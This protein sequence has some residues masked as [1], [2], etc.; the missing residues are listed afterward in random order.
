MNQL[1]KFLIPIW[2]WFKDWW[3]YL[4]PLTA[5]FIAAAL[6][7]ITGDNQK[8]I[9]AFLKPFADE[10]L[11]LAGD[12][13]GGFMNP[14]ISLFTLLVAVLVW[15]LQTKELKATTAALSQQTQTSE[16]QRFENTLF[17]LVEHCEKS[18]SHFSFSHRLGPAG[19]QISKSHEAVKQMLD[20]LDFAKHSSSDLEP[21]TIE[22]KI[23]QHE[24]FDFYQ[25]YTAIK[26]AYLFALRKCPDS[27]KSADYSTMAYMLM[28]D[29]VMKLCRYWAIAKHD[30]SF[31]EVLPKD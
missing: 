28:G 23:H 29:E 30:T 14:L 1:G 21:E 27:S 10:K 5:L 9:T 12:Y 24:A 6:L 2:S 4:L 18:L 16:L 15:R 26:Y 7:G 13:F 31:L 3:I 19:R 22:F 25:P 8:D 17:K 11:G 20:Q